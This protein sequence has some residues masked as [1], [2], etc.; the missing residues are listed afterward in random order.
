MI[1]H[2]L[3]DDNGNICIKKCIEEA[4]RITKAAGLNLNHA[5]LGIIAQKIFYDEYERRKK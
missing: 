3:S 2:S 4:E 5:S 1:D